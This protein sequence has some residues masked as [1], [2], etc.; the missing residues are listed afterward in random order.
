MI[1]QLNE[2]VWNLEVSHQLLQEKVQNLEPALQKSGNTISTLE[3]TKASLILQMETLKNTESQLIQINQVLKGKLEAE[4]Q[5]YRM[6]INDQKF[7]APPVKAETESKEIQVPDSE[8]KTIESTEKVYALPVENAS[9][10]V[11]IKALEAFRDSLSASLAHAQDENALLKSKNAA[12]ERDLESKNLEMDHFQKMMDDLQK[13]LQ[14][15]T[16]PKADRGDQTEIWRDTHSLDL[17]DTS[18][19]FLVNNADSQESWS[20]CRT[21]ACQVPSILT[22]TMEHVDVLVRKP[23]EFESSEFEMHV[24]DKI[25]ETEM[26]VSVHSEKES[27]ARTAT[28][29]FGANMIEALTYTM[30]GTWVWLCKIHEL[31]PKV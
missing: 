28:V 10:V 16:R 17:S 13:K 22:H 26:E 1:A 9:S 4:K 19:L 20:L 30:I 21:I 5:K 27:R 14:E 31:V 3:K 7:D 29:E 25:I 24:T 23:R 6:M 18:R 15:L 12:L 11:D 2:T 8:I